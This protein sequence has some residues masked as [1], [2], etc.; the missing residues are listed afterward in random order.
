MGRLSRHRKLKKHRLDPDIAKETAEALPPS[1]TTDKLP[2]KLR[3][4]LWLKNEAKRR[5]DAK[6]SGAP[7][8]PPPA[9][10]AMVPAGATRK[11]ISTAALARQDAAGQTMSRKEREAAELKFNALSRKKRKAIELRERQAE[12]REAVKAKAEEERQAR[13]FKDLKDEIKFGERAMTV[14]KLPAMPNR[15]KVDAKDK[16]KNESI[17]EEALAMRRAE[18]TVSR[19]RRRSEASDNETSAAKDNGGSSGDESSSDSGARQALK[20]A[21]IDELR[22]KARY[23]ADRATVQAQ[24]RK[25]KLLKA[26]RSG[27]RGDE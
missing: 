15:W 1:A 24:Y 10:E 4:M 5:E 2:K 3:E 17:V 13:D 11:T 27:M 8:A 6:R 25:M 12:R 23:E 26:Q 19:K 20:R 18:G 16:H 22:V 21:K 9:Q 14:P 7:V